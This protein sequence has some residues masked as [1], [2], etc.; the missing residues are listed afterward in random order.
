MTLRYYNT[1][2]FDKSGILGPFR[3]MNLVRHCIVVARDKMG[4]IPHYSY[5][6]FGGTCSK[7]LLLMLLFSCR[8]TDSSLLHIF[9]EPSEQ[10]LL[11]SKHTVQ[12][13]QNSG[14]E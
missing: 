2:T 5:I 13:K 1:S 11:L 12:N 7:S 6:F 3:E 8:Y 9:K 14:G 10:L 4:N